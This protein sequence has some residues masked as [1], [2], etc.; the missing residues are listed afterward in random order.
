M[1]KGF[2]SG[3]IATDIKSEIL[4][5][6]NGDMKKIRF[7]IACNRNSKDGGADFVWVEAFSKT[8]EIIEKYFQRGRGIY[9]EYHIQTGEYTTKEGKKVYTESKII[10]RWEFPPVRKADADSPAE[11]TYTEPQQTTQAVGQPMPQEQETEFMK[12][13]DQAILDSLPFR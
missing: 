3:F 9:V 11:N 4:N 8:A 7:S 2:A 1:N 10:D 12:I 5:T 13:P 6:K